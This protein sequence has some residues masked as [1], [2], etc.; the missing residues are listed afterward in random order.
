M[1]DLDNTQKIVELVTSYWSEA[2]YYPYEKLRLF[3]FTH[4]NE[5]IGMH[6]IQGERTTVKNSNPFDILDNCGN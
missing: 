1:Y 6:T 4:N 3:C 2:D 5:W